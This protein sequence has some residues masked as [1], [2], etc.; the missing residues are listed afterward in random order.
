MTAR[1]HRPAISQRAL[2]ACI[3]LHGGKVVDPLTGYEFTADE[4][5]AGRVQIDHYPALGL[6][7]YDAEE[8]KYTPD[9]NDPRHLRPLD[10]DSHDRK[11]NGP[12]GERRITTRGSDQHE[13]DRIPRLAHAHA[14]HKARLAGKCGDA[15]KLSGKI[16]SRGFPKINGRTERR[17]E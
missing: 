11:T 3:V 5:M 15:R 2:L 10:R 8:R 16:K 4:I 14:E 7:A 1:R 13:I 17:G 12:G 9:A 6:R